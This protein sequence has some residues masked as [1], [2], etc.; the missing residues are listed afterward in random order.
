M[1]KKSM[2]MA[3]G[4]VMA[5]VLVCSSAVQ[6]DVSD[7][8]VKAKK[9]TLNRTKLSMYVGEKAAI[10]IKK[11]TP[12]KAGKAVK[13]KSGNKSVATVTKKGVVTAVS[14]GNTKITVTAKNNKKVKKTVKVTVKNK[15]GEQT[16]QA[17]QGNTSSN[18]TLGQNVQN[19][20][21]TTNIPGGN[22][23]PVKTG[24]PM[25]HEK[26]TTA[27]DYSDK[28]ENDVAALKK[29]IKEQRE[30][31]AEVSEDINN[32][33]VYTWKNGRLVEI[34]WG[35]DGLVGNLN[36]SDFTALESLYCAVNNLS[37]LDVRGCTALTY[38]DCSNNDLSSLD[39]TGCTALK[40]LEC[41]ENQLSSLDVTK[42]IKLNELDCCGNQL[43][44]ID[45]TSCTALEDLRCNNNQLSSLNVRGC[46]ALRI[47]DC[48]FNQLTTLDLSNCPELFSEYAELEY[49]PD[50]TIVR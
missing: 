21:Q 49:D 25:Q 39:V 20:P 35:I 2:R 41:G 13:Y 24:E 27:P 4:I 3:A 8:A 1:F 37:S 46:T 44:S 31:G 19:M 47:L 15:T 10:K 43:I 18:N 23:E 50:V 34:Y 7:A 32:S 9:I 26:P 16:P 30:L 12:K 40:Y 11:V 17:A 5:F 38:L 14:A 22:N 48:S 45:I 42:C 29:I 28:N 36:L 6:P 33:N